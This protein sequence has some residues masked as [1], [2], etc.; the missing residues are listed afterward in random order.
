M[1]KELYCTIGQRMFFE[2]YYNY[3]F[4]HLLAILKNS[5]VSY[6]IYRIYTFKITVLFECIT[7]LWVNQMPLGKLIYTSIKVLYKTLVHYIHVHRSAV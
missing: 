4:S 1:Q 3:I 5:I 6:I 2:L 7:F